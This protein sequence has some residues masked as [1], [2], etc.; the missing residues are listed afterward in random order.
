VERADIHGGIAVRLRAHGSGLT[1]DLGVTTRR[2]C[3][4][5]EP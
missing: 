4:S 5:L 3:L 1:Q 2:F